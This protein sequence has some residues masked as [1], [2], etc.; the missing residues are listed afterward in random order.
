MTPVSACRVGPMAPDQAPDR[1]PDRFPDQ[2][3]DRSPAE[4]SAFGPQL[5]A[6][7]EA[8]LARFDRRSVPLAGRR[9]AAVA[10]VVVDSDPVAD[11]TDDH[12]F[13]A[14]R[15]RQIDGGEGLSGSV[16]GTAGAPGVLLTRL[17]ARLHTLSRQR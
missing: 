16:A 5:R 8:N 10:V 3:P 6:H 2:A 11:G 17:A 15:M 14:S 1:S 4:A 7:L 13:G 12:P 9:H